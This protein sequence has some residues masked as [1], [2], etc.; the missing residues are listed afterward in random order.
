LLNL[1]SQVVEPAHEALGG[2][3]AVATREMVGAEVS[4]FDAV[5][6]LWMSSPVRV[7]ETVPSRLLEPT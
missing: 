4:V 1:A 5:F 3:G 2:L 6:E 7:C